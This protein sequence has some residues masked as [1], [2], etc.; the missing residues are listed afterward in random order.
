M[1]FVSVR[2]GKVLCLLG[3]LTKCG[4][5]VQL[6]CPTC[7]NFFLLV[8]PAFSRCRLTRRCSRFSTQLGHSINIYKRRTQGLSYMQ[9]PGLWRAAWFV[10][11]LGFRTYEPQRMSSGV[12]LGADRSTKHHAFQRCICT[13]SQWAFLWQLI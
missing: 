5:L 7:L 9:L 10:F 11:A 6:P 12:R 1:L 13:W 2:F 8:C 4:Q 3:A